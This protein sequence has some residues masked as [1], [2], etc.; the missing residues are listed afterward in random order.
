MKNHDGIELNTTSSANSQKIEKI[1][2]R[3]ILLYPLLTN[4][5]TGGISAAIEIDEKLSKCGRYTYCWPRDAMFITKAMDI[6]KMEKE[7][8]KFYK[9]FCK[10][11]QSK[12]GM[13]EQRFYTDCKLAP[14]WGYQIDETASVVYGIYDHYTR[15]KDLKFLKENLKM[16]EKAT[17]FLEKYIEDIIKEKNQMQLSYDLWEMYEGI[18]LYS[19]ATIFAAFESMLKIYE[20]LKEEIIK[21]RLKQENV[22]KQKDK[23]E[24]DLIQIK[25]YI[26]TNLYDDKKKSFVRNIEDGK[27]DISILGLVEPFDI[28]SPKE[29][30]ITNTVERIN[31]TLRTYTGGYQRFEQDHYMGGNPWVIATLWMSLYYIKT[32]EYKKAKECFNFV[33]TTSSENGFLAEQIDNEKLKP[34]WI[35][36]L[37]WSH[38]MYIIVL[39]KLKKLKLI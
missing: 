18:H 30:K 28:F 25:K 2:K 6:L 31:L 20:E 11:T 21:N 15:T 7:T 39:E 33:V 26:L 13:W 37:G 34:A 10:N 22:T 36:G 5:E 9:H 19:I 1:Y 8:E 12:N 3:T 23:L 27:I 29:N 35:I 32:K 4:L 17:E 24:K 14:C 16:C 38:A